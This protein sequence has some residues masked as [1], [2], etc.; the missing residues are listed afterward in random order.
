MAVTL[1]LPMNTKPERISLFEAHP[2]AKKEGVSIGVAAATK[3][4]FTVAPKGV[5]GAL[6]PALP[7]C[8]IRQRPLL[9][10]YRRFGFFALVIIFQNSS[11]CL[12]IL[13]EKMNCAQINI[14]TFIFSCLFLA[15]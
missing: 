6:R 2:T 7:V 1:T 10:Y 11:K 12:L 15:R 14:F 13:R 9:Y 8:L 5:L 4:Y 3:L